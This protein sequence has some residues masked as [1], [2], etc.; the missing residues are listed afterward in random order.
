MF[1]IEYFQDLETPRHLYVIILWIGYFNS[2]I[3]PI[4]YFLHLQD[5]RKTIAKHCKY[6][7]FTKQEEN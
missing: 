4:I 6:S 2:A 5:I 3:N 1:E 7:C